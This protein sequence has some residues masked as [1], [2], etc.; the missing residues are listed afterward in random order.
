MSLKQAATR[1]EETQYEIFR[2]TARNI[3]TT[4]SDALRMF[5]YAFN[6]HRGFPYEVR[7]MKPIVEPFETEEDAT[8]FATDVSMEV[9]HAQ[10]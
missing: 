5:I 9:L 4:P 1:V 8:R 10:R 2:D 7:T 3:G 6:E